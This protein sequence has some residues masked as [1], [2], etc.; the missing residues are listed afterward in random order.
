ML[1]HIMTRW[2]KSLQ[3][4]RPDRR[5]TGPHLAAFYLAIARL[6]AFPPALHH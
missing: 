4:Q 1:A 3:K 6:K 2:T 5:S